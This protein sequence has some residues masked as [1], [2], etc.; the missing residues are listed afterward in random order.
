MPRSTGVGDRTRVSDTATQSSQLSRT[1]RVRLLNGREETNFC[2]RRGRF[3]RPPLPHWGS[4]VRKFRHHAREL[5]AVYRDGPKGTQTSR[6]MNVWWLR[7]HPS[8]CNMG[9]QCMIHAQTFP[10]TS[11][12]PQGFKSLPCVRQ[13]RRALR[14][15]P[16]S[17]LPVLALVRKGPT[18]SFVNQKLLPAKARGLFKSAVLATAR[19]K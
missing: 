12:Q 13:K 15:R 17:F 2:L 10:L 7:L 5:L 4:P 14:L 18:D 9:F 11:K 3:S 8:Q 6:V 16:L 1:S 19:G